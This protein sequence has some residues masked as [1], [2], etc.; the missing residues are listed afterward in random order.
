[1]KITIV[2][3]GKIKEKYLTMG[4]AEFVK[5]LTPYCRL[6]IIEV[7]DERM[8]DNP[9]DADKTKVL[10][11]E[12]ERMMKHIKDG[13]HLI[14]L[15]VV[16]KQ[17]S[18]EELAEKMSSLGLHGKSD[19]TFAIGGAFGLSLDLVKAADERLSFSKMTF[20]HQMIRLL[21]VEQ[22]YRGFKINRGEPYH[23]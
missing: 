14:V 18:S 15:D 4:I 22:V 1:M 10:L 19:I 3:V 23:W 7:D 5:R 13:T 21:L 8:P 2:A 6:S 17:A 12:G 9:S 20:T 16:G 11:K